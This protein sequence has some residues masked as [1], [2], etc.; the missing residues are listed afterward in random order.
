MAR[1][2]QRGFG[3]FLPAARSSLSRC[4]KNASPRLEFVPEGVALSPELSDCPV[5]SCIFNY[6]ARLFFQVA[7][8]TLVFTVTIVGVKA[9][10]SVVIL[11]T[12]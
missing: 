11:A 1:A 9:Q 10:G 6:L 2:S 7:P 12:L 4:T 3:R 8:A 5:S